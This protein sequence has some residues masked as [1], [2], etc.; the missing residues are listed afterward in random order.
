MSSQSDIPVVS[1]ASDDDL[2]VLELVFDDET[3]EISAPIKRREA[4]EIQVFGLGLMA[5]PWGPQKKRVKESLAREYMVDEN[6]AP[7]DMSL[8]IH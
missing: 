1:N 7:F 4:K 3:W 6:A 5:V 2:V 8:P